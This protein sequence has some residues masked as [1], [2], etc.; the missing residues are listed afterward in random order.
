[1][2]YIGSGIPGR[3]CWLDLA[4]SDLREAQAFYGAVF[5]WTFAGTRANGGTYTRA[6]RG[7]D[8]VGSL[9][10]LRRALVEEGVPSH[11]TPYIE[12][13]RMDEATRTVAALGGEVVV[14]PFVIEGVATIALVLDSVGAQV[15]LWQPLPSPGGA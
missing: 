1:M 4:A 15:G 11:W 13:E 14:R 2:R 7:G 5:G 6:V 10:Q 3:F 9:Y 8:D 12:V